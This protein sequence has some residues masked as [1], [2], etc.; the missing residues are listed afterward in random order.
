MTDGWRSVAAPPA[1]RALLSDDERARMDRFLRP[2]DRV[3]FGVAH[4]WLRRVLGAY[5]DMAPSAL[6]FGAG[7]H[8]K[9]FLRDAAL[10][11]NLSHS[12]DLALV[13]VAAHGP[14]GVDVERWDHAVECLDLAE[15]FFSAAEL[16]ALH[17][18]RDDA[19]RVVEGFF[20]TWSRK[21]AYLKATGHGITRGLR[22]FD[23]P[24]AP[25]SAAALLADRLDADATGRWAIA[26]LAPAPSYSGA[27]VAAAPLRALNLLEPAA[28]AWGSR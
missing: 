13:A 18:L 8:G 5:L 6:A 20:A 23:V 7:E 9:P 24:F 16:G 21:E 22:H 11:F 2:A 28:T 27:L 3:R 10:E 14:V 12:G 26:E 1:L 17:A 4:G 25:G 19:P 15:R